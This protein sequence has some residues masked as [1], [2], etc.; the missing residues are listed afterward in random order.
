VSILPP[1]QDAHT[2]APR[3]SYAV[4]VGR[5]DLFVVT[6]LDLETWVPALLRKAG[7]SRVRPGAPGYVNASQGVHLLGIPA[8]VDRSR[9]D[10]HVYGNPH[11]HTSPVNMRVVVRNIATALTRVDPAHRDTYTRAAERVV[12]DLDAR[13]FGPELVAALGGDLAARLAA[14]GKLFQLLEKRQYQGRPMSALL[15][16]WLG[17]L[18]KARGAPIATYHKNWT[19]LIQLAGLRLAAVAEPK[20]GVPPTAAHVASMLTTVKQQNVRL[21]LAARHYPPSRVRAVADKA[22]LE[23]TMVPFHVGSDGTKTYPDLVE[24]WVRALERSVR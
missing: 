6:G 19:Y 1:D 4:K 2:L 7:N 17:R 14:K 22:G 3:P 16:G 9:G 13:T 15:G 12:A 20:P 24:R 8:S 5:A 10:V 21:L 11:I 23:P 18:V